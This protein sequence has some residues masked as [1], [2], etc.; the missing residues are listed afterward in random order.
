MGGDRMVISEKQDAGLKRVTY[1]APSWT[2]LCDLWDLID[3][4]VDRRDM[5]STPVACYCNDLI[6]TLVVDVCDTLTESTDVIDLEQPTVETHTRNIDLISFT[7]Y[8]LTINTCRAVKLAPVIRE[9]T[10]CDTIQGHV[11][12]LSR[13]VLSTRQT[14]AS[15]QG[16]D[17]AMTTAGHSIP[18]NYPFIVY[19]STK[20]AITALT[21]GLRR[22]ITDL[23]SHIKVTSLSPGTVKTEI[24]YRD[25][26][27][28]VNAD[29]VYSKHPYLVSED[30]ADALVYVLSTPPHVQE[31][32]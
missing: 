4:A 15:I 18:H 21:T 2:H 11:L 1:L 13:L 19:L 7:Y 26:T 9:K 30:V 12:F 25:N 3:V 16:C 6:D 27:T 24:M 10:H 31:K 32:E 28:T 8:T 23:G 29:Q 17:S 22:E 5:W 20:H 14:G